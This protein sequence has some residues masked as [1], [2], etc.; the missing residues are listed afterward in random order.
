MHCAKTNND[1]QKQK[2][3]N[4]EAGPFFERIFVT[5][6]AILCVETYPMS[7]SATHA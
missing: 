7:L 6:N 1:Q 4:C 5:S 3:S 2:F